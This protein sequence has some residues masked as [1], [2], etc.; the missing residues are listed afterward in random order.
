M[1]LTLF[2]DEQHIQNVEAR[3]KEQFAHQIYVIGTGDRRQVSIED[4]TIT[5]ANVI[6][7][8][9]SLEDTRIQDARGLCCN[10]E[11]EYITLEQ[12]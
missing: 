5:N 1:S 6:D 4:K 11:P 2:S 7:F 9:E 10:T 12:V 3:L 8:I